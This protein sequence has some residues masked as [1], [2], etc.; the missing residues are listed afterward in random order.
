MS[1]DRVH[2]RGYETH[3]RSMVIAEGR[4]HANQNRVDSRDLGEI[5]GGAKAHGLGSL[6]LLW[7]DAMNVG[8]AGVEPVHLGCIDVK[9]RDRESL[10]AEEQNQGEPHVTKADNPYPQFALFNQRQPTRQ[11]LLVDQTISPAYLL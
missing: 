2:G 1:D 11:T 3:I 8:F 9:A 4:G 5:R 10:L 6:N 7:V